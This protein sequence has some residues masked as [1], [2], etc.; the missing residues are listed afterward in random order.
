M[1]TPEH[2]EHVTRFFYEHPADFSIF[3]LTSDDGVVPH[4]KLSVDTQGDFDRIAAVIGRMDRPHWE[5]NW[6]EIVDDLCAVS[7]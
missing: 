6:R 1:R 3:N 2:F 5:Y 4:P 7:P